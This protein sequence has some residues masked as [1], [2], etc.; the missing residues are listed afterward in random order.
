MTE[1]PSEH[2]QTAKI[3][4]SDGCGGNAVPLAA[5]W[6]YHF[7]GFGTH[8]GNVGLRIDDGHF[9]Q[10]AL[11]ENLFDAQALGIGHIGGW[12]GITNGTRPVAG[13]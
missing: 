10:D 13:G 11:M 5:E 12:D 8:L 1:W 9:S 7:H 2:G 6:K 4:P 3:R